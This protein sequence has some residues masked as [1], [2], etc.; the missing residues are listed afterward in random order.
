MKKTT[1][2]AVVVVT[3]LASMALA[4]PGPFGKGQCPM[5]NG[6]GMGKQFARMDRVG[7]HQQKGMQGIQML[8]KMEEEL[9]LSPEQKTKLEKM[10]TDFAM[11][12]IDRQAALEKA[13]VK[14]RDLMRDDKASE[15]NVNMAIDEV[16]RL[17]ADMQKMRFNHQ[18]QVKA[19][20]NEDQFK[21]L[22]DMKKV[23]RK[24]MCGQHQFQKAQ[25]QFKQM[26]RGQVDDDDI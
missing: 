9:V 20:L 11:E 17:K 25:K 15:T 23:H 8:L 22:E 14:L 26:R 13:Q 24:E 7:R 21:K 5:G 4:Q 12:R 18:K 19:T 2:I 3:M 10:K 16:S 1:L 6:P